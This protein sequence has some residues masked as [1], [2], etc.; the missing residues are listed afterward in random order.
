MAQDET[1][2]PVTVG[3]DMVALYE[4]VRAAADAKSQWTRHHEKLKARLLDALGYGPED[5]RPASSVA[6]GSDG[7]P[8]FEVSV[9]YRRGLDSEYLR[10]RYPAV[11]AECE[12]DT[13]VKS[14]RPAPSD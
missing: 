11:Y 2:S 5:A 14:V 4:E 9:T 7:V 8:A 1:P 3:E 6:L 12:R 10:T 13:P